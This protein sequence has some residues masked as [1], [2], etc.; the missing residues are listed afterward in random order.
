MTLVGKELTIEHKPNPFCGTQANS[1]HPD[2][3]PQKFGSKQGHS[4]GLHHDF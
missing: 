1:V 3:M 2:Q 4:W